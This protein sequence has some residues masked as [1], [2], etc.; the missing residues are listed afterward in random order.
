VDTT[1]TIK[2]LPLED[3][4]AQVTV[5]G[6][7]TYTGSGQEFEEDSVI[8]TLHLNQNL[9]LDTLKRNV[10]YDI[11]SDSINA[12]TGTITITGIGNYTGAVDTTFTIKPLSLADTDAQV[13]VHGV[14]TYTG[15]KQVF[16][17]DSIVV[18]HHLNQTLLD[19]LK[20]NVDYDIISDSINAGTGNITITGKGNYSGTVDTTFTIQPLPLEDTDAQVTV[21]G[22]YTYTG[23][24]QVFA[25]DSIVVTRQLNQTLLDT[26][27]CNV[28]YDIISDSINAGTGNIII[29]GKGNYSGT[30]DT[31]F[32]IQ[33]L[34]LEDADAQVTVHGVYIYTGSKQVFEEDSVVVTRHLTPTLLD[35]LKYNVDYEI[36][37]DSIN[38]GTGNITIS[39]K[40][41]YSGEVDTTF[42]IQPFR[43]MA[44]VDPE[45]L[46]K[47]YDGT[48]TAYVTLTPTNLLTDD[49]DQVFAIVDSAVYADKNVGAGIHITIKGISLSGERAFNY[50]AP[51]PDAEDYADL[52]GEIDSADY[53]VCNAL[54]I[55]RTH[56]LSSVVLHGLGVTVDAVTDTVY[57]TFTWF[58]DEDYTNTVPADTAFNESGVVALYWKFTATTANYTQAEKTGGPV[59]ITVV[60]GQTQVVTFSPSGDVVEKTFGEAPFSKPATSNVPGATITYTSTDP[61]IATVDGTGLVAIHKVGTTTITATAAAVLGPQPYMR[62]DSSYTLIVIPKSINGATVSI[63]GVYT[64]NRNLQTPNV[65]VTLGDGVILE[66]ES[67]S[68]TNY[69]IGGG[70]TNAG[71]HTVTVSGVGNYSGTAT[72]TFTIERANFTYSVS[73]QSIYQGGTV[74]SIQPPA[75]G[76][77]ANDEPV[78]GTL[79]WFADAAHSITPTDAVFNNLG[80]KTLYWTFTTGNTN[81]IDMVSGSTDFTV[82]PGEEQLIFFTQEEVAKTFGDAPFT[83][84]ATN[85]SIT[86]GEGAVTYSS[87]DP[88]IATVEEYGTVTIHKAGTT[89][90][91]ATAAMVPG[92]FKE[93]VTTYILTVNPRTISASNIT[94]SGSRQY[95]GQLQVPTTSMISVRFGNDAP[96]INGTDYTVELASGGTNAGESTMRVRGIGNYGGTPIKGYTIDKAP[97]TIDP[98]N[99]VIAEK[100]YNGLADATVVSVAFTGFIG[101]ERF[102]GEDYV[103]TNARY[104]SPNVSN[105]NRVYATVTLLYTDVARN[106]FLTNSDFTKDATIRR[107]VIGGS[108]KTLEVREHH[109]DTYIVELSTLLPASLSSAQMKYEVEEAKIVDNY[110]VLASAPMTA[111]T[112]GM[113][114][115]LSVASVPSGR[116]AVVPIAISSENFDTISVKIT[117]KVSNRTGVN[118]LASTKSSVYDGKPAAYTLMSITS[119][120]NG[121]ALEGIALDALYESLDANPYRSS[122]PPVNTGTYRLTLSV[123]AGNPSYYGESSPMTFSITQRPIQ[124]VAADKTIPAGSLPPTLTYR[125]TD[126]VAGDAAIIGAPILTAPGADTALEGVY[127]IE[128]DLTGV[129]TTRNYVFASTAAIKG[130]LTV[131]PSTPDGIMVNG[132][133]LSV[134]QKLIDVGVTFDLE[135]YVSPA[136][137]SNKN[138]TWTTSNPAVAIVSDGIVT[139]VGEGTAVITAITEDGN[140]RSSCIVTTPISTPVGIARSPRDVKVVFGQSTLLINSPDEETIMV[141]SFTGRLLFADKKPAGEY[142]FPIGYRINDKAVIVKGSTGWVKKISR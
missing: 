142:T 110:G 139:A 92:A 32:T 121:A 10:D 62:T 141:Y 48:D 132:I 94:I 41:N 72:S 23:S 81:Y 76:V 107:A 104:N 17:E 115:G 30:M 25:E 89:I 13:T 15:S 11:S 93:T 57:G 44:E 117:I 24:K 14:Y 12:G 31:T 19:T 85:Y 116:T 120:I 135:A 40:G 88:T 6:V 140:Y 78:S 63:T 66:A 58:A 34:S 82:I 45:S 119:T 99:S 126:A 122:N 118:I 52:T 9:D 5:H 83:N 87:A 129:V 59:N 18:T 22:V 130:K 114:L 134:A 100:T 112:G 8:V 3:T 42:I 96:L 70:G 46:S 133:S 102:T 28:D 75:T 33:P 97:L 98:G 4:D 27:K 103:V 95:N 136:D 29:H 73:P 21:H 49:E 108:D 128:V 1:F 123:A 77:G 84:P 56:P 138:V 38:A 51:A 37:S 86:A 69:I 74:N 7:Y 35:T 113:L 54:E 26:L 111:G 39:G 101:N 60:D 53:T 50:E 55:V 68:G 106:Y 105:A 90:I 16:D 36:I 64:Y 127:P 109:A 79:A 47:V 67:E 137:A 43:L 65:T 20:C 91:T 124:V 61:A 131:E 80:D 71:T 125:I 2:P